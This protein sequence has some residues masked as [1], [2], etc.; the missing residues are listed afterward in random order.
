MIISIKDN[1][2]TFQW[3]DGETYCLTINEYNKFAAIHGL[4]I[5]NH[6]RSIKL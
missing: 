5:I 2:V 6:D 1:Y 3:D 4:K